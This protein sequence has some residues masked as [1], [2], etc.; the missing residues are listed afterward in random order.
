ME[1]AV[2]NS[3]PSLGFASKNNINKHVWYS[4]SSL[5]FNP[6]VVNPKFGV[7][8]HTQDSILQAKF[9]HSKRLCNGAL[10]RYTIDV[11][12]GLGQVE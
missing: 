3:I 1:Y 4:I 2:W 7:E 5:V 11:N 9:T 6:N 10:I 12:Q 8:F